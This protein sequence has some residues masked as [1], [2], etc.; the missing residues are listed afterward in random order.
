MF[1]TYLAP[2]TY[3]IGLLDIHKISTYN[4]Q[5]MC[6]THCYFPGIETVNAENVSPW[7]YQV[8]S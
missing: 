6:Y 1:S 3:H 5:G 4:S 2:L 7:T 8:L